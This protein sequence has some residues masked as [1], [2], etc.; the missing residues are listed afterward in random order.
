MLG[1]ISYFL[2]IVWLN[3]EVWSQHGPNC[4]KMGSRSG[5]NSGVNVLP[6][7]A[8]PASVGS[9]FLN[10]KWLKKWRLLGQVSYPIIS[11]YKFSVYCILAC[12][13][14]GIKLVSDSLQFYSSSVRSDVPG[15]N[16][17]QAEL[18]MR[19]SNGIAKLRGLERL[20]E[21]RRSF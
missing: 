8:V 3:F 11:Y 2:C 4:L 18:A 6:K 16:I 14:K 10:K 5:Q 17:P 12:S 9:I 13:W 20:T 15:V 19:G 1:S 7:T 21:T